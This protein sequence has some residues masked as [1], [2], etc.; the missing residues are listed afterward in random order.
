MFSASTK[1]DHFHAV[2]GYEYWT[3]TGK[4][5][6]KAAMTHIILCQFAP[7]ASSTLRNKEKECNVERAGIVT[8]FDYFGTDP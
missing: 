1:K 2:F 8:N 3:E 4:T 7:I 6:V 5:V